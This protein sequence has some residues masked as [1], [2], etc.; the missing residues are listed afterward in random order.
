MYTKVKG[1]IV[2][3][4]DTEMPIPALIGVRFSPICDDFIILLSAEGDIVLECP[5][6]TEVLAYLCQKNPAIDGNIVFEEK[7]KYTV[8]RKKKIRKK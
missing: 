4:L 7:I 6:K 8:Y 5:F 2:T 1:E 3:K